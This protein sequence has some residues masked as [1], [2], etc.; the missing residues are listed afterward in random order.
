MTQFPHVNPLSRWNTTVWSG[1]E[2]KPGPNILIHPVFLGV[3]HPK[4]IAKL[5]DNYPG[6]LANA[7]L[8]AAA[9]DL[10]Q[11]LRACTAMLPPGT[12]AY[13]AA[14]AAIAKANGGAA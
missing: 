13:A 1:D 12:P 14:A 2:P 3:K 7:H 4:A 10:L 11:A 6:V 9:P 8:M 5:P